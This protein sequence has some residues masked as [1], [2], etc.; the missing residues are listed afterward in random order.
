MS[1][2][3]YFMFLAL[4]HLHCKGTEQDV[5]HSSQFK[6]S[7]RQL[8]L[9]QIAATLAQ[10][11]RSGLIGMIFSNIEIVTWGFYSH[12]T[13]ESHKSASSPQNID[14]DIRSQESG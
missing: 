7:K 10:E 11:H 5:K 6:A 4:W 9:S 13:E 8:I 2:L 3:S 1:V 14:G 12:I